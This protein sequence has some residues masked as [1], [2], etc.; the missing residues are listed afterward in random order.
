MADYKKKYQKIVD[1][2]VAKS[3][4][5]LKGLSISVSEANKRVSKKCSV[6]TYYFI[7]FSFVKVSQKLRKFS[8]KEIEAILAHEMGH[9]LRFESCGFL[10]KL[11]KGFKYFVF[12]HH[13]TLEENACDKIA[14]GRGYAKGLYKFK[15]RRRK[16]KKYTGCYLSANDVR[17]YAKRIGKW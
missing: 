12:R 13:R 2:L 4:P 14:I 1:G 3:F 8:D 15:S 16:K 9:I 10:G 17:D 5:E 11:W 6:V 7:W